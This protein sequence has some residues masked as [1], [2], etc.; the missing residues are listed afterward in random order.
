MFF[1]LQAQATVSCWYFVKKLSKHV[2]LYHS[3]LSNNTSLWPTRKL[4]DV[5]HLE[6]FV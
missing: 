4:P 6:F 2:E 1:E 3:I 5:K